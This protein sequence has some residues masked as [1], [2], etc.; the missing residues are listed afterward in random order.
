MPVKR[1]RC[2]EEKCDHEFEAQVTTE[3][4][5]EPCQLCGDTARVIPSLPA[6][7]TVGSLG[8]GGGK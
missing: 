4:N 1:F 8:K 6:K 3:A 7:T 5:F 2:M